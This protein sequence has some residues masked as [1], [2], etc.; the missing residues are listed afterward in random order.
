MPEVTNRSTL[1]HSQRRQDEA[2]RL[3]R[4][5]MSFYEIARRLGYANTGAASNARR[6]AEQRERIANGVTTPN[7]AV[8]RSVGTRTSS[9]GIPS[10]RTFGVEAE[11]FGITPQVAIDA[12]AQV[13]ITA[14]YE[15]YTHSVMPNWKIVTDVSVNSQGTGEGRGLELVSPILR[16]TEGLKEMTKALNALRGAGAKVNKTCGLHVH[17]G[18]DGL[19]GSQIMKI[20]EMYASNENN[21]NQLVSESRR[22]S[23]HYCKL[24]S[25]RAN[26]QT[27][28]YTQLSNLTSPLSATSNRVNPEIARLTQGTDRYFTVNV[29]SY[30]KYGTVEFRQHQ[31]TLNGGKATTWVKFLLGLI[32]TSVVADQPTAFATLSEMADGLNLHGDVKRR[33]VSRAEALNPTNN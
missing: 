23:N 14:T 12:L 26:Y 13:G 8:R 24:L 16:G 25:R 32:E 10:V 28:N 17:V 21:I 2:L 29:Q 22:G 19:N 7:R 15:G 18:M 31:G 30:A 11:F 20:V 5:G 9:R 27:S 1:G 6:A 3:R 4:E 33:L